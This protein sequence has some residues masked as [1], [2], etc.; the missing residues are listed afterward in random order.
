[1]PVRAE[2]ARLLGALG[3]KDGDGGAAARQA[4]VALLRDER[5][6]PVIAAARQALARLP[7]P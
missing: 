4:L 5:D 3:P 7:P 6:A 2:M 1:V